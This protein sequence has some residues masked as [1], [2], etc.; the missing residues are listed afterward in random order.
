G[1]QRPVPGTVRDPARLRE[2]EAQRLGARRRD[3]RRE[4]PPLDRRALLAADLRP[5]RPG[6]VLP[7]GG[8]GAR[9][10]RRLPR[11]AELRPRPRAHLAGRD[12]RAARALRRRGLSGTVSGAVN[13]AANGAARGLDLLDEFGFEAAAIVLGPE[14]ER[15]RRGDVTRIR[16]W[17]S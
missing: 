14:G 10:D 5:L 8:P 16:P 17:R 1:D 9:P 6:G 7:V 12:R 15:E 3:P 13:I 4:G 11:R 2:A